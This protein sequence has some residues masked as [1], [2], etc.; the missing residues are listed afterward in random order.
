MLKAENERYSDRRKSTRITVGNMD[1]KLAEAVAA[2]TAT[3]VR[4]VRSDRTY[5][6]NIRGYMSTAKD[7]LEKRN[8]M[9]RAAKVPERRFHD[10][11]RA[12]ANTH[13]SAS[14]YA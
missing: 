12:L 4:T 11:R 5:V 1:R 8:E 7:Y 10:Y 6:Q 14:V 13:E 3:G 9:A 2:R